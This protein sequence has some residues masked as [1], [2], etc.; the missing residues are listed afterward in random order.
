M[1]PSFINHLEG[2]SGAKTTQHTLVLRSR[3]P[4][5]KWV[6]GLR[7]K[8]GDQIGPEIGPR[9]AIGKQIGPEIGKKGPLVL[10]WSA[11]ACIVHA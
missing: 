9:I 1:E 6:S 7:A 8:I 10:V 3:R 4:G 2:G 5:R 11:F